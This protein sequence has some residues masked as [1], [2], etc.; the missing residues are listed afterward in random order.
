MKRKTILI[1]ILMA[2]LL[3]T[4][5]Q[6]LEVL[7]QMKTEINFPFSLTFGNRSEFIKE[8]FARANFGFTFD[9]DQIFRPLS[10]FK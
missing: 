8:K 6:R 7:A 9:L 1:K 5:F 4:T 10:I 3:M 2:S